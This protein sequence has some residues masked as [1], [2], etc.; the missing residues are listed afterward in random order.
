MD[1][2]EIF[3][4]TAAHL[5]KQKE[6]SVKLTMRLEGNITVCQYRGE[7]DLKCAFGVFIPDEVYS[8]DLEGYTC[9]TLL[10]EA[11]RVL[12]DGELDSGIRL[13]LAITPEFTRA[14]APLIPFKNELRA[15]QKIHDEGKPYQ[16]AWLLNRFANEHGLNFK[17]LDFEAELGA[18]EP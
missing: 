9:V 14:M 18:V 10:E 3:D 6:K 8:P 5:A 13:S 17:V 11:Q 15:L 1:L 4:R 12:F 2:Q 16:W 7:R